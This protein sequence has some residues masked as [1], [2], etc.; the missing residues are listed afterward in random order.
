MQEAP[1]E[2]GGG[3]P[4]I[5]LIHHENARLPACQLLQPA[6]LLEGF[7]E[8]LF[9]QYVQPGLERLAGHR[10]MGGKRHHDQRCVGADPRERLLERDEDPLLR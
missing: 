8:G 10:A 7:G 2:G 9:D 1:G 4:A 6:R 3:E 5:V